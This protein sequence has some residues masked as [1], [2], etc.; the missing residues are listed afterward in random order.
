MARSI[1]CSELRPAWQNALYRL[2]ERAYLRSVDGFVFN[3]ETTRAAVEA[4]LARNTAGSPVAE[5]ALETSSRRRAPLMLTPR[6]RAAR[7]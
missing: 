2:V 6:R 7:H 1:G 5:L 4:A 3:S